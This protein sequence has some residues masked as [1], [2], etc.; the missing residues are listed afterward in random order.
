MAERLPG[1]SAFGT[2]A[3]VRHKAWK[4]TSTPLTD[5]SIDPP[6]SLSGL[7]PQPVPINATVDALSGQP[8]PLLHTNDRRRVP[9]APARRG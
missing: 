6:R 8:K 5:R 9:H 2:C 7:D 4:S 1:A 3:H